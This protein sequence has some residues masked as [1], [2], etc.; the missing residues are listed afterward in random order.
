M[1]GHVGHSGHRKGCGF[2]SE[3]HREPCKVQEQR[4]WK[5]N[6]ENDCELVLSIL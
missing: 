5:V 2:Y 4:T 6:C 1:M 3:G